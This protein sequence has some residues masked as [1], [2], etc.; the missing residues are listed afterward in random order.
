M[1]DNGRMVTRRGTVIGLSTAAVLLPVVTL[2]LIPLRDT[3]TLPSDLLVYLVVVAVVAAAG[4]LIPGVLAAVAAVGLVNYY[5]TPPLHTFAVADGDHVVALV[6]F[7]GAA[8]LVSSLVT[9]ARRRARQADR[10]ATVAAS[11]THVDQTRTALLRAVGH[12]LRTPLAS[13]RAALAGL[14][15]PGSALSDGQAAELLATADASLGRLTH[16]VESLLDLSRLEA[17]SVSVFPRAVA[18]EDAAAKAVREADPSRR[19]VVI[20]MPDDLPEAWADP[21]LLERVLVNLLSNAVRYQTGPRSVQVVAQAEREQV[22]VEVRD[23]GPGVA[24]PDRDTLFEAF[25]RRGD[26]QA[27]AGLGLGLALARGLARAM[28]GDITAHDTAGGGLTMAVRLP[29]VPAVE[30]MVPPG[31][32]EVAAGGGP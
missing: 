14:R 13:A 23:H 18:L 31:A 9:L 8:V 24:E 32:R 17:G 1:T 5:F 3:L 19:F 28:D 22:V 20:Q 2:L 11:A 27:G 26:T 25:Q 21:G 12:D 15:D 30:A 6:V 7:V 16:L 4:E 29:A 10:A